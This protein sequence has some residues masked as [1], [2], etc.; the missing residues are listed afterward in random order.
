MKLLMAG[1][2]KGDEIFFYIASQQASRLNVMHLE[3]FR[4]SALLA[5]P[6]IASENL[7]AKT[8]IRISV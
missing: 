4:I 8:P 5:S 7:L 6:A 1:T 2:A 3:I